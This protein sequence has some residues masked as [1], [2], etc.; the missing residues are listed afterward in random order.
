MRR[1]ITTP[2]A[3]EAL[4][5][6]FTPCPSSPSP[7]RPF[8]ALPGPSG[9]GPWRWRRLRSWPCAR[10]T[11][12][13]QVFVP[14]QTRPRSSP[15]PDLRPGPCTGPGARRFEA[16]R[17]PWRWPWRGWHRVVG[18]ALSCIR[19]GSALVLNVLLMRPVVRVSGFG[20]AWTGLGGVSLVDGVERRRRADQT[21]L[22]AAKRCVVAAG[23][24]RY[25]DQT[26]RIYIELLLPPLS[27]NT[28]VCRLHV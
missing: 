21:K 13:V 27:I 1:G 14:S 11:V 3:S 4:P 22:V 16:G 25:C 17:G 7:S 20:L 8:Q 5:G 23:P 26:I 2:G 12:P 28:D 18:D 9:R 6:T 10:E 19:G 24:L 15:G